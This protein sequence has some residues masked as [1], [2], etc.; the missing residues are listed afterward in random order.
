MEVEETRLQRSRA[1]EGSG[2]VV[3]VKVSEKRVQQLLPQVHDEL[4][5][6][7]HLLRS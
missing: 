6:H 5:L 1:V 3:E 7:R 4:R 2:M